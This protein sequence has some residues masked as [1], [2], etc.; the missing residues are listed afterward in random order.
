[1]KIKKVYLNP[2]QPCPCGE[3]KL[4]R[5]CCLFLGQYLRKMPPLLITPPPKTY[6]S[7]PKCYLNFTKD[8][9]KKISL[10]HYMS[11]SILE[12]YEKIEI[13]GTSWLAEGET[14][15]VGINNLGANIL[16]ERHNSFLA[17]LDAEAVKFFKIYIDKLKDIYSELKTPKRTLT[18]ISGE[19]LELW[20]LKYACGLFYSKLASKKNKPLIQDHKIQEKYVSEALLYHSW[21][22]NCGLYIQALPGEN[23]INSGIGMCPLTSIAPKKLVGVEWVIVGLK[24]ILIFDPEGAN[25]EQLKSEGMIH[26]PTEL[27]LKN[28]KK[29]HSIVLTWLPD[30]ESNC[31]V[32]E[33]SKN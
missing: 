22:K 3:K 19:T 2:N 9:S 4:L 18:F 26:R 1:M 21:D 30:N 16:C 6:F 33:S 14:K 29:A 15:I 10:E 8:C 25:E 12:C 11:K 28:R 24:I 13:Q 23:R 20:M 32:I 31:I 7:N 5:H 17:P 27:V